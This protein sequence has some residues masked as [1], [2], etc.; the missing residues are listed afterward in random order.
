MSSPHPCRRPFLL[1]FVIGALALLESSVQ[2]QADADVVMV[3]RRLCASLLPTFPA[4]RRELGRR[5]AQESRTLDADGS[6]ADIAYA[7]PNRAKWQANEHLARLL[8]MAKAYHMPGQPLQNDP[9][10]KTHIL[11]ALSFW[12]NHDF[13]N[14]N[15][16][17]NQIGVP[18][19][20]GEILLLMRADITP[21]QR[22]KGDAILQRSTLTGAGANLVWMAANQIMRG[23]L[24]GSPD[25][26][27]AAYKRLYQE[28]KI[29]PPTQ[30]GVQA[31]GSFHQHGAQFY[32]GGY[33]LFF[34][35]DCARF[36]SY[37][38]GTRFQSPAPSLTLLL[39][40]L[41]DGQQWMV[42]GATFDYNAIGR[43][44]SRPGIVAAPTSW[45][46]GPIAPV[47]AAYGLPRA[48]A[49][50]AACAVPR[51][52][53]LAAFARRLN[54][55]PGAP[56]LIGDRAFRQSDYL[57]HERLGFLASLKLCSDRMFNGETTNGEGLRSQYLSYGCL[58]IYRT[59]DEYRDIFPVWDWRRVPG[60]TCEQEA[61]PLDP[62]KVHVRG[63][64]SFVGSASD[65][66]YGL[67]VQD[68]A[69]GNVSGRKAWF[70]LDDR[71]VCLGAGLTCPTPNA[72]TTSVNQCLRR[73]K[74]LRSAPGRPRWVWHDG[75]GYALADGARVHVA[76]G[77][78][79]GRWSDIGAG[80][81]APVTR[82]VFSLWLDHGTRASQAGYAYQILPGCRPEQI[83]AIAPMV[84][85]VRNTQELQA[86]ADRRRGLLQAAFWQAG[87]LDGGPRKSV[88]VDRPCLL[89]LQPLANGGVRLTVSN[90]ENKPLVV[91]VTLDGVP[92]G[93][94]TV[95]RVDLPGGPEAGSS[96]VRALAPVK[97]AC[98]VPQK[99]PLPADGYNTV[100]GTQTFAAAYQ[101]TQAPKLVETA[102]AILDM[103]SRTI[104][105][106]L[107]NDKE[108][109]PE[110]RPQSLAEIVRRVPSVR[111]VLD[112]P[113]SNYL[114]WAYPLAAD[115]RGRFRP[116]TRDAEYREMYD[117]TRALLQ[118]Y[119][120]TG[121]T[122]YLGNWE[123]DWHLTHMDPK[124]APTSE[125]IANMTGWANTRQKA[126]DDAKRDT[127]HTGVQ[128]YYYLEVNRVVDA[129]DGK[130]RLTNAV[131]P[132]AS[133]DFVSYSAYDSL[134]GDIGVDLPKA[135]D[136]IQSQLPPKPG[137]AGRRVFIGEY[138]F[139]AEGRTPAQ[140]DT[141]S[142]QVMR[143]G[144]AWGCP[145]VL[146]WEM[147][148]N[149]VTEDGRQRGFWLI[150]NK[151]TK[152]PAYFTHQRFY[153]QA[154][155]Y[156]VAFQK[157]H[158]RTPSRAEFSKAAVRWLAP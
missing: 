126:V 31:D 42:R 122:F 99:K 93:G 112:M 157:A 67:A 143:A 138:G 27:G 102:R 33:G 63:R 132:H 139:P 57:A 74:V 119:N 29:V 78:Q 129:I 16:W 80:S 150:D 38:W 37:A 137:I 68:L 113:F 34:G 134:G 55:A 21:A 151:N 152:Q 54:R 141:L 125:E 49:L 118:S 65:G 51:R 59:G 17:W 44:I 25:I 120:G 40:Y 60:T 77:P 144:L 70:F 6:W 111:A 100:I 66:R 18:Q 9:A 128:V 79:T 133:V 121:K 73:G 127:P 107:T 5:V 50:L 82:D 69:L 140:Q 22:L 47:G 89:L 2:V 147:F 30:E 36:T 110:P 24:N 46:E 104:K 12:L 115:G 142:R 10:L 136:Y 123:G 28:I 87:H 88:S 158:G 116:D 149:E 108:H 85:I 58:Y 39:R 15:W 83:D 23:C 148:N 131:L 156:V 106:D 13:R 72:L 98:P 53:E 109:W 145:F 4:D 35:D 75:V 62:A 52:A 8:R 61:G 81:D 146:Y 84:Q 20:L 56:P 130:S 71:V 95:V 91:N 135:L 114:L 154:K 48:V 155:R 76:D 1:C 43:E 26:V 105:F 32:S 19:Q 96:L 92:A 14:P 94:K 97:T 11:R 64:T 41:L 101:F 7:D 117:L 90:P 3:T 45:S 153:A 124:Y 103:G 86:V